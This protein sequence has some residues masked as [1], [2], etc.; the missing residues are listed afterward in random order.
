MYVVPDSAK[1]LTLP[2]TMTVLMT[3][4]QQRAPWPPR[5]LSSANPNQNRVRWR[6]NL[7]YSH[8][9]HILDYFHALKASGVTQVAVVN[10]FCSEFPTFC[11]STM[12]SILAH[13][14]EIRNYASSNPQRLS[15]KCPFHVLLPRVDAAMHEWVQERICHGIRLTGDVICKKAC[16]FCIEFGVPDGQQ[17]M[18]SHGWLDRFKQQMGLWEI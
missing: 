7:T 18:F 3:T 15:Y 5:P 17:P 10:H 4:K 14:Q 2:L 13:E 8:R 1:T 11:T 12:S 16:N 6:H 9:T